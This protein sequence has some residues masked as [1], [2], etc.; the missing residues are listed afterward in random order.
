MRPFF[1]PDGLEDLCVMLNCSAVKLQPGMLVFWHV[2]PPNREIVKCFCLKVVGRLKGSFSVLFAAPK[3]EHK[4]L[5]ICKF[6]DYI[7]ERIRKGL[8]YGSKQQNKM[9]FASN[10]TSECSELLVCLQFMSI[11]SSVEFFSSLCFHCPVCKIQMVDKR[12]FSF[13]EGFQDYF[14]GNVCC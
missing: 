12:L 5:P 3:I 2:S 1:A 4:D 6:T 9:L 13:V 7:G 10:S 8:S 11:V 14:E